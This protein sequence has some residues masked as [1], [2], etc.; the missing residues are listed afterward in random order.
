MVAPASASVASP[1]R[2]GRGWVTL[3]ASIAA[4]GAP[5]T[6]PKPTVGG[7]ACCA[8]AGPGVA[9]SR[10]SAAAARE[11]PRAMLGM[12]WSPVLAAAPPGAAAS[13]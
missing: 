1:A 2:A 13:I 3:G 6:R 11:A 8:G 4:G 7:A 9:S 5:G 12:V 10:K